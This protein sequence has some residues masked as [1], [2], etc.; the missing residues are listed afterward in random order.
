MAVLWSVWV[1]LACK[2]RRSSKNDVLES[3]DSL[4]SAIASGLSVY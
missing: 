3:W 1:R 2:S 4:G